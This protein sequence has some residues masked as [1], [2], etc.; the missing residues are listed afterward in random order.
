[1]RKFYTFLLAAGVTATAL[2]ASPTLSTTKTL[3]NDRVQ[4][5]KTQNE[6]YV[7]TT[8]VAPSK[9]MTSE[10][11]GKKVMKARK[12]DGN[13]SIEGT[14]TFSL[15]DYYFQSSIGGSIEITYEAE[16]D[17]TTVMFSDPTGEEL[18]F[19]GTYN[20]ADGTISFSSLYL[21]FT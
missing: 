13:E 7:S 6:S 12:A 20:Q 18:P 5:V 11:V 1:M 4:R 16:V 8:M 3:Q 9:A 2:A 14:W 17:G 21:G 19:E 10:L 15:G